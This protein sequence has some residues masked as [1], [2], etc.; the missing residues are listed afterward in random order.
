MDD[1]WSFYPPGWPSCPNCGR[2]AL[3][4]HLTCGHAECSE[5]EARNAEGA[6]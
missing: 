5:R 1:L 6:R 2:P 3:D 4:G